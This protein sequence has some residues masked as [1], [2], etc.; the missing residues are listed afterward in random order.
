MVNSDIMPV[1]SG[2]DGIDFIVESALVAQCRTTL[3]EEAIT[4]ET[5]AL[6]PNNPLISSVCFDGMNPADGVFNCKC[7]DVFG[8]SSRRKR[9]FLDYL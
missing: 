9:L 6:S 7:D 3:E 8:T 5:R 1:I 4:Q 2:A